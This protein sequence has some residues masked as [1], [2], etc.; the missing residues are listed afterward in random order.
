MTGVFQDLHFIAELRDDNYYC[1]PQYSG[2]NGTN[3]TFFKENPKAKFY[4][5]L[6]EAFGNKRNHL[7]ILEA[8]REEDYLT[9]KRDRN[10]RWTRED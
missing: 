5:T 10:G 1:I 9:G 8:R 2:G 4:D 7:Q 3:M 6:D